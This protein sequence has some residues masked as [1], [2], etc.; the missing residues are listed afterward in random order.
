M[1]WFTMMALGLA[2]LGAVAAPRAVQAL[3]AGALAAQLAE[4]R[5]A[6]GFAEP[7]RRRLGFRSVY[8][9]RDRGGWSRRR[10]SIFRAPR[11]LR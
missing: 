8:R 10:G 7:V 2:M 9:R 1:R 3:P 5:Q 4:G 11:W 6:V